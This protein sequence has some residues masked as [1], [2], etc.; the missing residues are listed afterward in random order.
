MTCSEPALPR[1]RTETSRLRR[2]QAGPPRP[3]YA[4]TLMLVIRGSAPPAAS[5]GHDRHGYDRYHGLESA[6]ASLLSAAKCTKTN[7]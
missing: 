4:T 5:S 2:R 7:C 6:L 3:G 1:R